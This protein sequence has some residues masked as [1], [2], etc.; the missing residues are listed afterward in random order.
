[1]VS[2]TSLATGLIDDISDQIEENLKPYEDII[3]PII[4]SNQRKTPLPNL[5]GLANFLIL[6]EQPLVVLQPAGHTY[7]PLTEKDM[8]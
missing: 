8:F 7:L 2:R 6:E 1:M 4:Y 3:N 5:A